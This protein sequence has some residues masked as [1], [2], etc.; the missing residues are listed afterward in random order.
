[1][2]H[3]TGG[4]S[5]SGGFSGGSFSSSSSGGSGSRSSGPRVSNEYFA[6]AHRFVYYSN[7]HPVYYYSTKKVDASN[8]KSTV[9]S[10]IVLMVIWLTIGFL[11]FGAPF[12]PPEPLPLTYEQTDLIVVDDAHVLTDSEIDEIGEVFQE[13]QDTTGI[14]P[15]LLTVYNEDWEE[16]YDSIEAYAFDT[17][18]NWFDDECHWLIVYS[19]PK[20]PDPAF[21][22]WKWWGMIGD[23]TEDI[24]TESESDK[25]TQKVQKYLNKESYSVGEAIARGFRDLLPD[26][27]KAH[28][29]F[30][31]IL[32]LLLMFVLPCVFMLN[33]IFEA[34]RSRGQAK[35]VQC[36]TDQGELQ[37]DKCEYCGGIY[38]HGLH[39]SCPH[40][41]APIKKSGE[42]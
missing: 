40:C 36:Q 2:P 12:F 14:T 28:V 31:T 42:G 33:R 34:I 35:A 20:N 27:M 6:G 19:E 24:I 15:A 41:G 32:I 18:V 25:L 29:D 9:I 4:G 13:F 38:V 37:E 22:D 17:Y 5:H 26:V 16:Y 11:M 21:L 1:M 10:T 8:W 7:H 30:E 39:E 3:S 23:D